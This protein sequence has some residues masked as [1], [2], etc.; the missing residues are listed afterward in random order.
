[1]K[2][3][4]L[5]TGMVVMSSLAGCSTAIEAPPITIGGAF[6]LNGGNVAALD[7]TGSRG[8]RMAVSDR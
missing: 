6:E 7:V 1:M 5:V 8:A 4:L 3:H 2:L